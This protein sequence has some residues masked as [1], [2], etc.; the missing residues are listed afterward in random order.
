MARKHRSRNIARIAKSARPLITS[1][2]SHRA[3]INSDLAALA[4]PSV[5]NT[6]EPV[7]SMQTAAAAATGNDAPCSESSFANR[8][9]A[10]AC[11]STGPRTEEGKARSSQNSL[12][13]GL[14]V[15]AHRILEHENSVA[16]ETLRRQIHDAYL[17]QSQRESLAVEDI[18]QCRWALRRFDEAEAALLEYHFAQGANPALDE[19]VRVPY[20]AALGYSA[21]LEVGEAP[22][23]ELPSLQNL[24]RYRRH[25]ERRHREALAEFDRAQKFRHQQAAEERRQREEARKV[26]LH[27][28]RAALTREKL[29]TQKMRNEQTQ[30]SAR[31]S[32]FLLRQLA[33]YMNA[34]SED[35]VEE[36]ADL[37]GFVSSDSESLSEISTAVSG[38]GLMQTAP[39][40]SSAA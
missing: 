1:S 39:A 31:E 30:S 3:S 20:G 7:S 9:R 38:K 36:H 19:E 26:E 25:W 16:W 10:N 6:A 17:P 14:S 33:S 32:D 23:P 8:N 40:I 22:S 27:E 35:L 29:L 24:L 15:T 5:N 34:A 12:K 2:A 11:H 18:A 21:I 28:L 13:H 37:L 4:V